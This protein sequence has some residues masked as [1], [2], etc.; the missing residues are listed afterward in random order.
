MVQNS[1][2]KLHEIS[3]PHPANWSS[4]ACR[5][6]PQFLATNCPTFQPCQPCQP[7]QPAEVEWDN[8]QQKN[9]ELPMRWSTRYL[10]QVLA[11]LFGGPTRFAKLSSN[12]RCGDSIKV[13]TVGK[14]WVVN[15]VLHHV[16]QWKVK[17]PITLEA[18]EERPAHTQSVTSCAAGKW[19]AGIRITEQPQ[20]P[21]S[22]SFML[23]QVFWNVFGYFTF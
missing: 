3:M 21:G 2:A 12:R 16:A 22:S 6:M 7:C 1:R 15:L 5:R 23:L 17:T 10:V 13:I 8:N 4:H 19:W 9:H 11:D 18:L 14:I 20:S